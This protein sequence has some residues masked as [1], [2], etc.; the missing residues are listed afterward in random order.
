MKSPEELAEQFRAQGLKVTPQRLSIFRAVHD[1]AGTHPTADA[2][3]AAVV[4]DMPTVSLKTVYQTLNDLASM[5]E[6]LHLD[7]GHG[8]ARFDTNLARHQHLVC[9]SCGSVWDVEVDLTGV[10]V[11]AGV[12]GDF[13]V[14]STDVVFRGQCSRCAAQ[15]EP[16]SRSTPR[17]H[18]PQEAGTCPS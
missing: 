8:A 7:L 10:R 2:V 11:P 12:A 18:T 15:G 16:A 6:L 9:E 14:S 13:R 5:G 4:A 1:A 17:P 3:Y